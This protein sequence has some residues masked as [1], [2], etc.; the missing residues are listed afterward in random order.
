MSSIIWLASYPKSGNTWVRALLANYRLPD[1]E[2]VDINEL[3]ADS[4]NAAARR[5]FD[6]W[7]GVEAAALDQTVVDRLRPDVYRRMAADSAEDLYL[8]VHDAWTTDH[9]GRAMFPPD[10]TS[11]VVYI[12]RNP[13]DVAVS[14]AHHWGVA[15]EAAVERM[16]DPD[17]GLTNG[18]TRLPDQLRQ[19]VGSWSGHV[20]SWLDDSGLSVH[21]VRYE[22]LRQ[23][24]ER[25]LAGIVRACGLPCDAE[26]VRQATCFADFGELAR[27][28]RAHGF[29][30][31]P[32]TASRAF[33]RRGEVG[34]WRQELLP[35]L[36]SRLMDFHRD[37]MTRFHYLD[38]RT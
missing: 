9:R 26:R 36:A 1:D 25:A 30:E 15:P 18:A 35:P 7:A 17:H 28:E 23:D 20:R 11:A 4:T 32:L 33:F 8:K 6:E 13:L 14:A 24:T 31:R 22:D 16:C 38:E 21:V 2:P 27:Q 29:R 34:A 3:G 10:V 19:L 5:T 12:I 37:T